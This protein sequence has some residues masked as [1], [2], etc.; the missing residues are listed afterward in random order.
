MSTSLSDLEAQ[1]NDLLRRACAVVVDRPG[2]ENRF[3]S[4]GALTAKLAAFTQNARP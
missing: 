4:V 3:R 2:V 1:R